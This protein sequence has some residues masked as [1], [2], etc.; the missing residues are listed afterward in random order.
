MGWVAQV[1]WSNMYGSNSDTF[2]MFLCTCLQQSPSSAKTISIFS[3]TSVQ[4]AYFL[5]NKEVQLAQ[6][7]L[8]VT[9]L[10]FQACFLGSWNGSSSIPLGGC[11]VLFLNTL[12]AIVGKSPLKTGLSSLSGHFLMQLKTCLSSSHTEPKV[13]SLRVL[14]VTNK[15]VME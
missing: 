4:S 13:G 11:F 1:F 12:L 10:I 5:V 8:D 7:G 6:W 2:A 15:N 9:T 14:K 3:E